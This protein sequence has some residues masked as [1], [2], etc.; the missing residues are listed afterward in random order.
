YSKGDSR[1]RSLFVHEMTHAWQFQNMQVKAGVKTLT[2][3]VTLRSYDDVYK[4]K[5]DPKKDLGDYNVEQQACIMEELYAYNER[6]GQPI[7][8]P[9]PVTPEEL[10]QQ[11]YYA[12][13]LKLLAAANKANPNDPTVQQW[14]KDGSISFD[15]EGKAHFTQAYADKRNEDNK[16]YVAEQEKSDRELLQVTANFRYNP[17]YLDTTAEVKVAA[18]CVALVFPVVVPYVLIGTAAVKVHEAADIAIG[19]YGIYAEND[20]RVDAMTAPRKHARSDAPQLSNYTQC[21]LSNARFSHHMQAGQMKGAVEKNSDGRITNMKDIDFSLPEN[22]AEFNRMLDIEIANQKKIIDANSSILPRWIRSDN[23]VLKQESAR[24]DLKMLEGAKR[25]LQMFDREVATYKRNQAEYET[26]FTLHRTAA[27][28]LAKNLANNQNAATVRTAVTQ[29]L[30]DENTVR[31]KALSLPDGAQRQQLLR[32][33]D[34]NAASGHYSL[35][36]AAETPQQALAAMQQARESMQKAGLD[37]ASEDSYKAFGTTKEEFERRAEAY[38]QQAAEPAKPATC[39]GQKGYLS[40]QFAGID[41]TQAEIAPAV[42][43]QQRRATVTAS[44]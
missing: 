28:D 11:W 4:Y 21:L 27:T 44:R 22:R 2:D 29:F 8:A 42:D 13:R 12:T 38:K 37:P 25:E 19:T 36:S 14:L 6:R 34:I 9:K 30:H 31:E 41:N 16:N 24:A 33:C 3:A 39:P 5:L 10:E 15:A 1:D 35:A 18:A 7:E 20:A 32:E 23:S 26:V 43:A 40:G 17:A